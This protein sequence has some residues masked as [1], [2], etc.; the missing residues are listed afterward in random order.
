M[1]LLC[2]LM[3]QAFRREIS[4]SFAIYL[5]FNIL[6]VTLELKFIVTRVNTKK[7]QKG[8]LPRANEL[9]LSHV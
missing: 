9:E 3:L 6:N 2:F 8:M 1:P 7:S 5:F 4:Q